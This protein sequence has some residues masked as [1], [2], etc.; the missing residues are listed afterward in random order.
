MII[1][2]ILS[3]YS[4]C[5]LVPC[6][7]DSGLNYLNNNP[8][9]D[10][11]IGTYKLDE[12]TLNNTQGYKNSHSAQMQ[13]NTDGTFQL[14]NIPKGTIDFNT[15]H[16]SEGKKINISGKWKSKFSNELKAELDVTFLLDSTKNNINNFT[17]TS[18]KIYQKNQ[19]AVIY[20]RVGDPDDCAAVRFKKINE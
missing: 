12:W 7:S 20:I 16:Y 11:L 3:T 5:T 6:F 14:I 2:L 15:L 19:N 8:K 18:W 10:F 9:P 17:S 1:M 4:S 13:I